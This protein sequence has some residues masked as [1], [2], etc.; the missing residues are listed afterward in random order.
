MGLNLHDNN[1]ENVQR[2]IYTQPRDDV[3]DVNG[4]DRGK[5]ITQARWGAAPSAPAQRRRWNSRD[6]WNSIKF[7]FSDFH[8]CLAVLDSV[9]HSNLLWEH[10][11]SIAKG[12]EEPVKCHRINLLYQNNRISWFS[13]WMAKSFRLNEIFCWGERKLRH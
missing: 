12:A 6:K 3:D 2:H 7:L 11:N 8:V 9:S 5:E 13:D 10:R 1:V 4:A